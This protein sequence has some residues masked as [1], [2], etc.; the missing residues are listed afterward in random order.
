MND[1]AVGIDIGTSNVRAVIGEYGEDASLLITGIGSAVST[2]LRAGLIV[3]IE[4][5][6]K[7]IKTAVENAEMMAGREV[8][9]CIT[10]IGGGQIESLISKG[11]VAIT[12]KTRGSREINGA[13]I[14]RVI[15]ASRAINIPLDR[16]IL[17]VI[18][19]SYIVDGQ[20]GI[21]DPMNMLG[22]RLEA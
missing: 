20:S 7:S 8:D 19:R 1:I 14:E 21:K 17:H 18:P 6:M 13:D 11:L 3:N 5:T 15:E 2:G 12:T 10:A 4:S 16:H 22:V 9:S